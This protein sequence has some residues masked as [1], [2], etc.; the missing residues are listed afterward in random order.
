MKHLDH[1]VH[2]P[3]FTNDPWKIDFPESAGYTIKAVNGVFNLFRDAE[4]TD[5]VNYPYLKLDDFVS[6]MHA[7]CSM[8]ADGPL[9]VFALFCQA[10]E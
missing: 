4:C 9:Y 8:I 2:A 7:M 10:N 5:N 3:S 1:S 6:D